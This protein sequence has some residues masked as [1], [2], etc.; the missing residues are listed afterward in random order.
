M[1]P[2]DAEG[3]H[4]S[5]GLAPCTAYCRLRI[6]VSKPA[7]SPPPSGAVPLGLAAVARPPRFVVAPPPGNSE[8]HA[9]LDLLALGRIPYV[10]DW[11][12][13]AM[14]YPLKTGQGSF[15]TMPHS[16]EIDDR[17]ILLQYHH[18]ER[19]FT[20]QV[21]DQFDTLYKE[22][23]KYGGR[24]LSITLHPWVIGQPYRIKPLEEALSYIMG[25]KDVWCAT[26]S[27]ILA[28]FKASQ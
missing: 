14:H 28:A 1:M 10:C 24:I 22:A 4:A 5:S 16:H 7:L 17:L 9:A 20:E 23:D 13:K 12:N 3:L 27:E 11:I 15:Y 26:G 25:H 19:D 2:R 18:S 6:S 21:K 8:S